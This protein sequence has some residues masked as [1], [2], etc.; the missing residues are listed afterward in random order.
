ML[1]GPLPDLASTLRLQRDAQTVRGAL[2][3]SGKE[4]S[5]GRKADLYAASGGDP[6]RLLAIESAQSRAKREA[7]GLAV[8]QGRI[9]MTQSVMGGLEAQ[10][11]A[12]GVELTASLARD[13]LVSAR[14]HAA[15]AADS[16]RGV[17]YSLN[18]AY[19]GRSLFSGA[20]VDSP[21]LADADLILDDVRAIVAGSTDAADAISKVTFYFDDPAGGF[22]TS[23]FLGA[24]EDAPRVSVDRGGALDISRRADDPE[25]RMLMR[26]LAL[27]A[28]A[29]EEGYA[30]PS[31]SEVEL[32]G[33]AART[34][35][36]SRE[37]I[38]K[39]RARLGLSEQALEEAA[40]R[41]AGRSD[42]LDIAWNDATSRDPV[43]AIAEFKALEQQLEQVFAVTARLSQLSLLDYL[44]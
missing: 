26:G 3:T 32:L 17:V 12:L 2:A 23:R 31:G 20:A 11:D 25:V 43:E 34:T 1:T 15:G 18:G 30:G 6:R 13:D 19:G 10:A 4:L 22:A 42:A 28:V 16:L 38:V 27:A 7:E 24:P 33:E 44:R 41:A 35:M 8:A 9:S 14:I 40:V 29:V 36:S 39:S 37:A 21:A 5:T